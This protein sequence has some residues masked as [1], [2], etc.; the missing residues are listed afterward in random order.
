MAAKWLKA[1]FGLFVVRC[2]YR[3]QRKVFY[4]IDYSIDN[5]FDSAG[6]YNKFVLDY[7][8]I[9]MNSVKSYYLIKEL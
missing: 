3:I 4:F 7:S 6:W 5:Q 8:T 1:Y 9:Q 2:T